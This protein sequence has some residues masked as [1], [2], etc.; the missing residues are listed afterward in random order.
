MLLDDQWVATAVHCF[1]E[2]IDIT[3]IIVRF[4]KVNQINL[5]WTEY[6][7][8]IDYVVKHPLFSKQTYDNDIALV[9]LNNSIEFTNYIMP[10]CIPTSTEEIDEINSQYFFGKEHEK[11]GYVAGW[12]RLTEEGPIP[13]ML[14]K[15]RLPI[16]EQHK[17]LQSSSYRVTENMFCAGYG[18]MLIGDSCRG[19]SGGPFAVLYQSRW[20]LL[21]IV[22]WGEGCSR[23]EKY[24]FYTKVTNYINWIQK[25]I[26]T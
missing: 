21:G 18:R 8:K 12:G 22:S 3:K 11:F 14:H 16:V 7:E 26:N 13:E 15:I 9:K 19:D 20:T 1:R 2:T 6:N 17:C 5:E 10:I 23:P 25:I 4:G 24:G